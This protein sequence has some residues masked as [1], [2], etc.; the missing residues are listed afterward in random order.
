MTDAPTP[1]PYEPHDWIESIAGDVSEE[2]AA[3]RRIL[4]FEEWFD[5]LCA[6]P[7]I[8]ARSAA[9]HRSER[10]HRLPDT[11]IPS[12]L[13]DRHVASPRRSCSAGRTLKQRLNRPPRACRAL[14]T[15][16][17]GFRHRWSSAAGSAHQWTSPLS[18]AT[19][20]AFRWNTHF[21]GAVERITPTGAHPVYLIAEEIQKRR[22]RRASL[23]GHA[24]II[25]RTCWPQT[26]VVVKDVH[27]LVTAA[28]ERIGSVT[29]D[30]RY[31][32]V[33]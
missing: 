20:R 19:L 2:F 1:K 10:S 15:Q 11:I 24:S 22:Y 6:A 9:D 21:C 28:T 8:H 26:A 29:V 17:R 32:V 13:A 5:L 31:A 30:R 4:S 23:A 18:A 12:R 14:Y 25:I 33:E 27:E 7:Q 3:T 16:G